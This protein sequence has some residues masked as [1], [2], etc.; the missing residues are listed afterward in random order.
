MKEAQHELLEYY[1]EENSITQEKGV[2]PTLSFFFIFSQ[3]T[4]F[5]NWPRISLLFS[6]R[7]YEIQFQFLYLLIFRRSY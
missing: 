7:R 1:M 6:Y 3:L 2:I 4:I 5:N